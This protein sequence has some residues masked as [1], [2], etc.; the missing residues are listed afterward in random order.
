MNERLRQ[1]NASFSARGLRRGRGSEAAGERDEGSR[2][3][4]RA[5]SLSRSLSFSAMTS[6]RG[7]YYR[8]SRDD[9]AMTKRKEEKQGCSSGF[10]CKRA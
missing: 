8:S 3:D 7:D 10:S 5:R 6:L 9:E 2:L 4:R 1:E